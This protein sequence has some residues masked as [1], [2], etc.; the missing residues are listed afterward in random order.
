MA[1]SARV[2]QRAILIVSAQFPHIRLT[3]LP[4]EEPLHASLPQLLH[5]RP[6]D[7]TADP[8]KRIPTRAPVLRA[9]TLSSSQS[10]HH[11]PLD[12]F[13]KMCNESTSAPKWRLP[14]D[15]LHHVKMSAFEKYRILYDSVALFRDVLHGA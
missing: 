5:L 13:I 9:G 14:R 7:A 12:L 3:C 4:Y 15:M 11:F 1:P 8:T 2:S 6:Q 10:A